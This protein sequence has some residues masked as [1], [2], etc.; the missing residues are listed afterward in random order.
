MFNWRPAGGPARSSAATHAFA[1]D[2]NASFLTYVSLGAYTM[3]TYEKR[4]DF[5]LEDA[6]AGSSLLPL[7]TR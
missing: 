5:R 1:V 7:A 2:Q 4:L 6:D 3:H